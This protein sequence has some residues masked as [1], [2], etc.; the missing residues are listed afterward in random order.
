MNFFF[1][2]ALPHYLTRDNCD[3]T[4]KELESLADFCPI[5]LYSTIYDIFAQLIKNRLSILLP[6]LIL[7]N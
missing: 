3:D 7:A 1:C 5:C 6:K 2:G 4:K